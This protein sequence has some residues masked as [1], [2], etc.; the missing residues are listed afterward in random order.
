MWKN[1]NIRI[2]KQ[3]QLCY[4]DILDNVIKSIDYNY[5]DKIDNWNKYFINNKLYI[6]ESAAMIIIM[7]A[8]T[9]TA[10]EF[11][12]KYIY[13]VVG[14]MI[15]IY[16]ICKQKFY[17]Y[18]N[19]KFMY[20]KINDIK[21]FKAKEISLYLNYTNS[22]NCVIQNVD[23]QF[24]KCM[25]QLNNDAFNN[26]NILLQLNYIDPQTI[27]INQYGLEQLLIKSNKSNSIKLAKYFNINVHQ[28]FTRKET[29]IINELNNFCVSSNI[30]FIYPY[31]V[32]N[33]TSKYIIDY[34]L[35]DYKIAIE[36]DEFDHSDRD[37]KYEKKRENFLKKKLGCIF[38]RCNPDDHK[39]TISG[40]LG[41]IHFTIFN[42]ISF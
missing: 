29:D 42:M 6:T 18:D 41:Q 8:N 32:K 7:Y 14:A 17:K 30:N 5:I 12:S 10:I 25:K 19:N 1:N 28:K 34:Y 2:N 15:E 4:Q 9:K 39:F 21:W 24:K 13:K 35:P 36:I 11:C 38:I 22:K 3:N 26:Y 16:S 37:P 40:L 31:S 23:K 20:F 27:F 33:K